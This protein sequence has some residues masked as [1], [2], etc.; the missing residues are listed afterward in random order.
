M[1]AYGRAFFRGIKFKGQ[2]HDSRADLLGH[3]F[4]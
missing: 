3:L 1:L 2:A 4:N